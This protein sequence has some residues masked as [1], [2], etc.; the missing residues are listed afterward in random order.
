MK[1]ILHGKS[2]RSTALVALTSLTLLGSANA[3]VIFS[4]DFEAT[5]TTTAGLDALGATYGGTRYIFGLVGTDFVSSGG[6]FT[7]DVLTENGAYSNGI[8]NVDSGGAGVGIGGRFYA[9]MGRAQTTAVDT[10]Q[11][12]MTGTDYSLSFLHYRASNSPTGGRAVTA[13]IFDDN[14]VLATATF[15]AV[16]INTSAETRVL[17]YTATG[18]ELGNIQIRFTADDVAQSNDNFYSTAIDNISLT[19]TA[20]P[21]PASTALLGLG[22]LAFLM[23]RRKQ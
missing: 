4:E 10:T 7:L 21:E 18:A 14:G 16:D 3:A 2:T 23:R 1:N 6:V 19:A 11:S 5:P 8:N 13:E 15:A 20:V 12:F 9:S 17:N 22:G